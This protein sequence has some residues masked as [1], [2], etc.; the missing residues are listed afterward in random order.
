MPI[1]LEQ[2]VKYVKP[3][4]AFL[5]GPTYS[6]KTLSSLLLANGVVQCVRKCSEVDAWK[7]IVLIDTEYGRGA[8]YSSVGPYNY[9]QIT[10]PFTTEKLDAVLKEI[11]TMDTIDAI[12]IDSLTHFWS[13]EGGLLEQKAIYDQQAGGNSYTNWLGIGS[14]FNNTIA[15]ILSSPKH[16]FIT[17]RAKSDTALVADVNGKMVPKT[18]GLKPELREGFDFECDVVFNV[19]KSDH[20]LL[21]EKGIPGM[22]SLYPMATPDLGKLLYKFTTENASQPVRS[23]EDICKSI[24]TLSARNQELINFVGNKLSGRKLEQ[25]EVDALLNLEKDVKALIHK[26][27][28]K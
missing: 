19:D 2:A 25:L 13:K 18:Y 24:R 5:F 10:A 9:Y 26:Q 12:I 14:K 20:T 7:H 27:Q 11:N 6:G 1:K 22:E 23:K 17:A 3:L 21:V 16:I 28:K 15:L 4:K 8:L